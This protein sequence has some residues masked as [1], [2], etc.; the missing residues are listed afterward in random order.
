MNQDEFTCKHPE[1]HHRDLA[2]NI[3]SAGALV[4]C[5]G[6]GA[7]RENGQWVEHRLL[8][9]LRLLFSKEK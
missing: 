2:S 8:T 1:R 5:R 7:L 6:C 9:M 3:Q 4:W